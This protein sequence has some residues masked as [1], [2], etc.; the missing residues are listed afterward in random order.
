MKKVFSQLPR[1]TVAG[2]QASVQLLK[3]GM[4]SLPPLFPS[5]VGLAATKLWRRISEGKQGK[6]E[7]FFSAFSVSWKMVCF[8]II[9]SCSQD[10]KTITGTPH[11]IIV[12][13]E[14]ET[15]CAQ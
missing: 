4:A 11:E 1:V 7:A 3:M 9:W 5:S 13:L 12:V 15:I 8:V 2:V 6:K 14:S 10:S